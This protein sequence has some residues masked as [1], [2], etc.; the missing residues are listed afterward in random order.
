MVQGPGQNG[1][2]NGNGN[3]PGVPD[4]SLVPLPIP[5]T[6]I[7]LVN[8][9]ANAQLGKELIIPFVTVEDFNFRFESTFLYNFNN[10]V[11]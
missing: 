1:N 11:F 8:A 6:T 9:A 5:A 2:G 4:F 3:G 7:T 10:G